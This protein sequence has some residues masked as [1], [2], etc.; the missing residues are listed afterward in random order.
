MSGVTAGAW[1]T[2]YGT[3]LVLACI[4]A[5]WL[6]RRR[7]IAT[8]LDASHVDLALPIAFI[9]GACFAGAL[10]WFVHSESRIA[11][12]A[13]VAEERRRLYATV[14]VVLPLLFAY[15]RLAGLSVRRFADVVAVPA[16]AFMAIVRIGC[17][18]A[19]CCFGDVSGHAEAVARI[20]DPSL[21]L[22]VQTV[23]WLSHEEL[24]W[25]VHY[26]ADSLVGAQH[27]A[28]RLVGADAA[29]ALP[30]H[31]VQLYET[32]LLALLALAIVRLRP[33]LARPGS[34]ALVVLGS[35]A[36]VEFLLEFLRGD[37]ALVLGPLTVNQLVCTAWLAA[38]VLLAARQRRRAAPVAA[39]GLRD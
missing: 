19:G 17:F 21:R 22:Q 18:L 26:P 2:P 33:V 6:A 34:E 13:F 4:A 38:A 11:G 9:T 7:A 30:V 37:N 36:G 32:L 24:P 39:S 29:S 23:P 15:C 28:L 3:M 14:F 25:A 31:P 16:L 27:A 35:Y 1:I 8:G 20:E 10:G 12:E 5:W